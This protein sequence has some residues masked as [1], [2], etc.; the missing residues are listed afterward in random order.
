MFA[1]SRN[2]ILNTNYRPITSADS[3][4]TL[5]NTQYDESYHATNEGALTESLCKHVYPSIALCNLLERPVVRILDLCFGLGYNT[6]CSL[7]AYQNFAGRLEIYSPENDIALLQQYETL[8]YPEALHPFLPLLHSLCRDRF[9]KSHT[10]T[11]ELHI[12]DAHD[13]LRN[14]IARN[15]C[16]DVIYQD[17]FSP[18]KNPELWNLAHFQALFTLLAPN[19]ILTTYSQSSRALYTAHCSG[20]LTYRCANAH[21]RDFSI[22]SK[23]ALQSVAPFCLKEIDWAHKLRCNPA[24]IPF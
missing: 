5:Y 17:P 21:G 22:C 12:G 8:H 3:S 18:P 20:F 10:L 15:L 2:R 13:Y 1:Q 6:L 9:Y 4:T 19:G 24:L 16:V 23:K 7:W 14:L 11:I